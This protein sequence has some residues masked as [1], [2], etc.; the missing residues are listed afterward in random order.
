MLLGLDIKHKIIRTDTALEFMNSI[1]QVCDF[2]RCYYLYVIFPCFIHDHTS[3]LLVFLPFDRPTAAFPYLNFSIQR[4]RGNQT[5]IAKEL[6]GA[7][8]MTK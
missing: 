1:M 5:E 2:S 7:I 3:S 8:V 6:V 4:T